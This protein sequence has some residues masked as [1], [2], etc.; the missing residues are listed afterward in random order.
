[1]ASNSG[2][3]NA[4]TT[5]TM[6]SS[7]GSTSGTTQ[8]PI[9]S[10][11]GTTSSPGSGGDP[12][13]PVACPYGQAY[14]TCYGVQYCCTSGTSCNSGVFGGPTPLCFADGPQWYCSGQTAGCAAIA[15]APVVTS[16]D[17]GSVSTTASGSTTGSNNNQTGSAGT[18][19]SATTMSSA[20][21]GYAST[22]TSYVSS[23][24]SPS[25]TTSYAS[26]SLVTSGTQTAT[27][28]AMNT[29]EKTDVYFHH[30]SKIILQSMHAN[31]CLKYISTHLKQPIV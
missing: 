8:T 27:L 19:S 23:G 20:S 4:S 17:S 28:C 3:L 6:L 1:L 9:S 21:T 18:S 7:S 29:L 14:F 11:S 24:T 22:S 25:S 26:S 2:S 30:Y 16:G 13:D 5:N 15:T 10:T 31:N 12:G